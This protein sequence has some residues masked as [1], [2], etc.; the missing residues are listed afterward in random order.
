[1]LSRTPL[2]DHVYLEL[3]Q[4]VQKGTLPPGSRIRD[5][6]IARELG[7]SR[8]PVREALIR[9]AREGALQ[10]E[11]GRGFRVRSLETAELLEVG[12]ILAGLEP[13]ALDLTGRRGAAAGADPGGHRCLHRAG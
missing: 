4:R 5:T 10:A 7:V 9:L 3:L 2:R 1:M 11:V 13:L 8:T 12:A 6:E